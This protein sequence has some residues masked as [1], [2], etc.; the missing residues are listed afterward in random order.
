MLITGSTGI[1]GAAA[2]LFT[3]EGARVFVTSKTEAHCAELVDRLRATGAEAAYAAADL[4]DEAQADA[5]VAACRTTFGRIDGLLAVAGGSG[6]RFGDEPVHTLTGEA[7]D[8][9]LAL[10]ARSQALVLAPCCGGC[11]R[12]SR[13]P[14]ARAGRRSSSPASSPPTRCRTSSRPTPTPRRRAPSTR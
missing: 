11:S 2:E 3:D 9:T 5:A 10:N 8:A 6:R 12:R 7:W 14:P 1:A 4:S 13:M